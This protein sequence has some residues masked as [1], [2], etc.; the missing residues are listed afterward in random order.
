M[1]L[2]YRS[3]LWIALNIAGMLA[4]LYVASELWVLSG[5]E[6]MPGGAGHPFYW[7]FLI[8][9]ILIAFSAVNL[10]ALAAILWQMRRARNKHALLVWSVV[11][12]L[13]L[14]ATAYDHHRAFRVIGPEYSDATAALR[15]A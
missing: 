5:E 9:P 1:K 2:T 8:V 13:W 14:A 3:S 4:Y 6:G 10:A 12:L 15:D 11:A 7:L